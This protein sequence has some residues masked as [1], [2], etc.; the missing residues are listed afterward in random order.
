MSGAVGRHLHVGRVSMISRE[1]CL[2]PGVDGFRPS[3]VSG[4]SVARDPSH[5]GGDGIPVI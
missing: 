1:T 4:M 3:R 2:V 5:Q